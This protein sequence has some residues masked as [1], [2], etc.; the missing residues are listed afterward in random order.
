MSFLHEKDNNSDQ[1]YE[2]F[3]ILLGGKF[4]KF[5]RTFFKIS[6]IHEKNFS[7]YTL[8]CTKIPLFFGELT[9]AEHEN[10]TE[11]HGSDK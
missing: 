6:T 9:A 3:D 4:L 1:N 8:K 2:F 5:T 7:L 10:Q 11:S